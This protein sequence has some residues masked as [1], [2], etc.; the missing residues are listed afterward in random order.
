MG[1]HQDMQFQTRPN[2]STNGWTDCRHVKADP[3][4]ITTGGEYKGFWILGPYTRKLLG[5][6]ACPL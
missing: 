6:G 2:A 4:F 1:D 3:K 5:I